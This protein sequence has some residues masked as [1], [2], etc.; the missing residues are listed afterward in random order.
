MTIYS[1]PTTG[2]FVGEYT[3]VDEFGEI[4]RLTEWFPTKEEAQ[5]FQRTGKTKI[6]RLAEFA[7]DYS[8]QLA[9]LAPRRS[10]A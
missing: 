2:E 3:K 8:R 6:D 9:L 7:N 5:L 1:D 10:N 4:T